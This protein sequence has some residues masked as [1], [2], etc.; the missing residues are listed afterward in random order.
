MVIRRRLKLT[1]PALVFVTTTVADWEPIF[2]SDRL[3]MIVIEEIINTLP[4]YPVSI[5]GYV[6]MPSHFHAILNFQ[7]IE[8]LSK[9][10][11]ALK[12]VSSRRIKEL[13]LEEYEGVSRLGGKFQLWKPR[14]DD[15]MIRDQ[16]QLEIKL[17]Y[18]HEN[19]VRAG[20][21]INSID[22]RYSSARD[23]LTEKK[24]LIE[25]NKNIG[26]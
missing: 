6:L 18:I 7:E 15:F 13:D 11:Q 12:S 19:P 23:W 21:V 1:G 2:S 16:K 22:Y 17:N 24:G 9:F 5:F 8:Q 20:L 14:F 3:A 10:M 25:I 4:L 26:W